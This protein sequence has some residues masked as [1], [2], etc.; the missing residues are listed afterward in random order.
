MTVIRDPPD[1]NIEIVGLDPQGALEGR[2]SLGG[3][4]DD[5][6]TLHLRCL[7]VPCK[8]LEPQSP[9]PRQLLSLRL[10]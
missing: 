5:S 7:G 4:I 9:D 8:V 2:N 1:G 3:I 6:G 10:I